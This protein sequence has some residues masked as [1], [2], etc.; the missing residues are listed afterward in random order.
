MD[1]VTAGKPYSSIILS[2]GP[3]VGLQNLAFL[4]GPVLEKME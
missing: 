4:D 3:G 2:Q 1:P